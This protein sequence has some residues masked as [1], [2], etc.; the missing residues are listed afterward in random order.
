MIRIQV[1]VEPVD[2][3]TLYCVRV[4][5]KPSGQVLATGRSTIGMREAKMAALDALKDLVK[6]TE[7]LFEMSRDWGA[8]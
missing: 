2:N 8:P 4:F 5:T 1:D 3:T 6:E 7:L